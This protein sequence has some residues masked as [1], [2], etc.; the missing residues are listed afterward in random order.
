M[1]RNKLM[2]VHCEKMFDL[3]NEYEGT[4]DELI[5]LHEEMIRD[6]KKIKKDGYI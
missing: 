1:K 4:L 3:D 5:L 6:I 2:V